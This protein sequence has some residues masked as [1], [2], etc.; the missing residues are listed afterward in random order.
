MANRHDVIIWDADVYGTPEGYD[1]NTIEQ[2]EALTNQE[3]APSAKLLAFAREVET[4]SQNNDLDPV[5][6]R[7]LRN[8]EAK[9]IASNT[10]AYCIDLPEYQW[11]SLLKIS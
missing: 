4:H 5:V 2:A 3:A 11:R 7:Y 10:A 8:F 1:V 9:I 6:L